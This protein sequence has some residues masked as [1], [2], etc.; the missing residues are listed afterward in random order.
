MAKR[1]FTS[2]TRLASCKCKDEIKR[3]IGGLA[4]T[5]RQV[6]E[7]AARGVPVTSQ[8]AAGIYDENQSPTNYIVEPLYKRGADINQLWEMEKDAQNRFL[9]A[10][11]RDISLNGY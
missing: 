2:V 9:R 11:K 4:M 3:T 7:M 1:E 5:P 6:A 8:A 10:R